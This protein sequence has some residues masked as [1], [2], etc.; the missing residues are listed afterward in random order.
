MGKSRSFIEG[1]IF[2]PLITFAFPVRAALLFQ[3][4]YGAVGLW[5]VGKFGLSTNV[6]AVVTGGQVTGCER[7]TEP[8][9]RITSVRALN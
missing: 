4:M 9:Q 1:K 2:S 7:E 6:S 3:A 5:I 8:F